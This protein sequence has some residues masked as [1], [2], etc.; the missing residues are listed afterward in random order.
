M[1]PEQQFELFRLKYPSI[2][3][4]VFLKEY[5]DDEDIMIYK[6]PMVKESVKRA[7]ALIRELGLGL[8]AKEEKSTNNVFVVELKK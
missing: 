1:T 5:G 6:T 2:K 7:N 4:K 8:I 3:V